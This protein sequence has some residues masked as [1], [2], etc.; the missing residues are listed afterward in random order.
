MSES[1]VL[2]TVLGFDLL[3]SFM[4]LYEM[5]PMKMQ[6][7]EATDL[8]GCSVL[9]LPRIDVPGSIKY[10]PFLIVVFS[11]KFFPPLD[12]ARE[13]VWQYSNSSACS[14]SVIEDLF[15]RLMQYAH[16][17]Q[18]SFYG[19]MMDVLTLLEFCSQRDNLDKF[20]M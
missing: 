14:F 9:L 8:T 4:L 20:S 12:I 7:H 10:S 2:L 1:G 17:Y 3:L 6:T 15:L 16:A 5:A 13:V 18:C 19:K 11:S